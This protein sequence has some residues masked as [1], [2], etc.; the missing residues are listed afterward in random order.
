MREVGAEEIAFARETVS[1]LSTPWQSLFGAV[2]AG[3]TDSVAL[4]SIEPDADART[5]TITGEAKDYLAA[6]S[7]MA[8]LAQQQA[9]RRVHL[10]RHE[11]L[12]GGSRRPLAF[13]ISAGWEEGL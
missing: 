11:T 3:H 7:Y 9:L 13:T 8:S 6:L 2:E 5:V 12:R 10:V 1:R 4:L